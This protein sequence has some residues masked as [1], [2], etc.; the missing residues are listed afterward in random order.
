MPKRP[1]SVTSVDVTSNPFEPSGSGA[2]LV[3]EEFWLPNVTWKQELQKWLDRLGTGQGTRSLAIV[4][5]YGSGKSYILHWLDRVEFPRRK[6]LTFY[7]ENPEVRF[8]DL[9]NSLLRR[10]GRK[11]FAKLLWELAEPNRKRLQQRSLFAEGFEGYLDTVTKRTSTSE[12][13]DLQEAIRQSE[14][15]ADDEIAYC[16]ARLIAETPRK[17]YFEYRDFVVSRSGSLVAQGQEHRYF[18]AILKTLRVA[19]NVDRVAFLLDEFE[20]ISLRKRLTTKD[21]QDY[22]VTLKRLIDITHQGDLWLVLA[23]TPDAAEQTARLDP[24][25]WDRCYRFDIPPLTRDDAVRLVEERIERVGD[26]G[27]LFESGYMDVLQ[28]TTIASP[29]RLVKVFHAAI[30]RIMSARKRLSKDELKQI[31]QDIYSGD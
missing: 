7:F 17:P 31:D 30:S 10:I 21:S 27:G 13:A 11:H 22:L 4:G 6:V 15:T 8:Y 18:A 2:P 28:P 16:L 25:F 23:M 19:D 29:R 26:P 20:Q 5:G 3:E 9:A 24:A 1:S 14:I 12:L